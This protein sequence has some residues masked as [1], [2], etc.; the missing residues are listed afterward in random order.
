[1]Q[2]Y[3]FY[4]SEQKLNGKVHTVRALLCIF[5]FMSTSMKFRTGIFTS[6]CAVFAFV[7]T[8]CNQT[9]VQEDIQAY[10]DCR[11]NSNS[12]CLELMEELSTKYEFSPDESAELIE[13][14]KACIQE[15][16]ETEDEGI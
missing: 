4:G 3:H 8:S 12:D 14:V 11:L 5:A 9:T 7:V 6:V 15:A 10:C 13:G 2:K 16:R 1:M